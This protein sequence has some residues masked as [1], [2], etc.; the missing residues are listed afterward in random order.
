MNERSDLL[1]YPVRTVY[2]ESV[3]I[4]ARMGLVSLIKRKLVNDSEADK[5]AI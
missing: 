3:I 4:F 2:E 1:Q 5:I